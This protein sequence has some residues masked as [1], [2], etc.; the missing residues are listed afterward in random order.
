MRSN[1]SV[2]MPV[3]L[4]C[5][6]RYSLQLGHVHRFEETDPYML[7]LRLSWGEGACRAF[8]ELPSPGW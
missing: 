8:A 1:L 2:G 4:T 7:S 6:T 3:D 5:Y